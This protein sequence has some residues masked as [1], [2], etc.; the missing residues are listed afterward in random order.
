MPDDQPTRDR[1]RALVREVLAHALPE[2]ATEDAPSQTATP[3][4]GRA[5]PASQIN[6]QTPEH[7]RVVA[8]A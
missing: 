8:F 6:V 5:A 3:S 4:P 2:G 1:V 7:A